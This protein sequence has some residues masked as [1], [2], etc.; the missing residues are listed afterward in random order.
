MTHNFGGV[1][2]RTH[3]NY[4]VPHGWTFLGFFGGT[5]GHLHNLGVLIKKDLNRLKVISGLDKGE[6]IQKSERKDTLSDGQAVQGIVG[7]YAH[8]ICSN[9]LTSYVT[10]SSCSSLFASVSLF[11]TIL[12]SLQSIV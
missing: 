9:I 8:I 5:G 7:Q 10:Q 6:N 11:A 4:T 3:R 2:D 12:L 1:P